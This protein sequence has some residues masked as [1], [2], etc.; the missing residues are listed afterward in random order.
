MVIFLYA[1]NGGFCL[2]VY[3]KIDVLAGEVGKVKMLLCAYC[4]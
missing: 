4:S 1:I 2:P 3:I